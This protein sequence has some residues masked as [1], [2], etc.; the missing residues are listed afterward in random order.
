[1][2]IDFNLWI[3]GAVAIVGIMEWAKGF[4]KTT[5]KKDLPAWVCSIA[6]P[7]VCLAVAFCKGGEILFNFVGMWSIS[8]LGYSLIIQTIE[9]RLKVPAGV[10]PETATATGAPGGDQT[11][12]QANA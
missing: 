1:M 10:V 12:G 6:L 8:Q 5:F 7:V 11:P 4:V 3:M 2:E 9:K